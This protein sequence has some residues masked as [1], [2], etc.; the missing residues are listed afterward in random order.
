MCIFLKS[1]LLPKKE[2]LFSQISLKRGASLCTLGRSP[3]VIL[4]RISFNN[5]HLSKS[6][7]FEGDLTIRKR[8]EKD[9]RFSHTISGEKKDITCIILCLQLFEAC[10]KAPNTGND[11]KIL[12]DVVV[13]CL[14]KYF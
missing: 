1:L 13:N 3:H 9:T 8:Y 4:N 11:V 2:V 5:V 12:P 14:P 10:W 6:T 7:F